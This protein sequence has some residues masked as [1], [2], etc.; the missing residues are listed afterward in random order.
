MD[1]ESEL[2]ALMF[3][4]FLHFQELCLLN[5]FS[6]SAHVHTVQWSAPTLNLN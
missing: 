6:G 4:S 2:Q 1:I 3:D 5:V